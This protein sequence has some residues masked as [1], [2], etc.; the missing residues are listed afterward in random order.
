MAMCLQWGTAAN[1]KRVKDAYR[2]TPTRHPGC[3]HRTKRN[4]LKL[5]HGGE[6]ERS[7]YSSGLLSMTP[8]F[9]MRATVTL[10]VLGA[11]IY[12]ILKK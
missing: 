9:F 10:I 1:L 5:P 4:L 6:V 12:V 11:S 7:A 3:R 8:E 2:L